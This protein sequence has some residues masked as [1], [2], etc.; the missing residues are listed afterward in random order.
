MMSA[1]R[2]A[3]GHHVGERIVFGTEGALGARQPRHPAIQAVEH[4]GDEDRH[5][6]LLESPFIAWTM[7]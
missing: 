6:R 5:R 7:A 2:R 1:G 3:K 4:H